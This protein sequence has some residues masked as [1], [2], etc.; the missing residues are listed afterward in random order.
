MGAFSRYAKLVVATTGIALAMPTIVGLGQAGGEP[1]KVPSGPIPLHA[2]MPS[3]SAAEIASR[4]ARGAN[5]TG[6]FNVSRRS[7]F[8]KSLPNPY[9]VNQAWYAMPKGRLLGGASGI[10]TDRDGVSIWIAERCG[11]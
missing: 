2:A 11:G 4:Q 3:L 5:Q 10:A 6:D 9:A 1:D 7:D 8:D